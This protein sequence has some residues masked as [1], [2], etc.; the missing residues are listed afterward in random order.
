[1]HPDEWR[2]VEEP[3]VRVVHASE[4]FSSFEYMSEGPSTPLKALS[5]M[6]KALDYIIYN[7][8]DKHCDIEMDLLIN[9]I[10]ISVCFI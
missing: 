1:M 6:S 2:N 9:T 8:L 4:G 3:L 5:S 7:S 10:I